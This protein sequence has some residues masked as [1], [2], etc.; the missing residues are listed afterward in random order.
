MPP[1][2]TGL[3][4]AAASSSRLHRPIFRISAAWGWRNMASAPSRA[5]VSAQASAPLG[6]PASSALWARTAA[7]WAVTPAAAG[8]GANT[9]A[10]PALTAATAAQSTAATGLMDGTAAAITPMGTPISNRPFFSSCSRTPT[11][12]IPARLFSM[13]SASIRHRRSSSASQPRPVSCTDCRTR[14]S[15]RGRMPRSICSVIRSSWCCS[16][17]ASVFFACAA[18]SIRTRASWTAF[19]SLSMDLISLL[20]HALSVYSCG[21][22]SSGR[23]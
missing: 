1:Y 13:P 8:C 17:R 3:P 5:A 23:L 9:T 14:A 12:F 15:R 2:S 6:R 21:S 18:S 16:K 10:F 11:H 4:V 19:R 7:V 20:L 22:R